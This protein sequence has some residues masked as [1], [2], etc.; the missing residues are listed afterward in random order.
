[1]MISVVLKSN[2]FSLVYLIFIYKFL[3]SQSRASLLVRMVIYISITL[4]LQYVLFMINLNAHIS[5][6]PYPS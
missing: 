6:A 1:M 4:I 3:I 2:I 5:P